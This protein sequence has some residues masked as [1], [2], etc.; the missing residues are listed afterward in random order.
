VRN[1]N[2]PAIFLTVKRGTVHVMLAIDVDSD[3]ISGLVSNGTEVSTPFNGWIELAA[4]IEAA[5][6]V[7]TQ[8][9]EDP[10]AISIE[11]L[12]SVPGANGSEL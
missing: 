4:F 2:G 12:G 1:A 9:A 5:R 8:T 3:P 6:S 11:T 10:R 7:T